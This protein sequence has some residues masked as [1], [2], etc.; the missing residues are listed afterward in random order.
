[1]FILPLKDWKNKRV[2]LIG[3]TH[4]I[5]R[6]LAEH[7]HSLGAII[8]LSGRDRNELTVLKEKLSGSLSF[9]LDVTNQEVVK[10][11]AD[12]LKNCWNQ[13]D[14]FIHCAGEYV[15]MSSANAD[16]DKAR[17]IVNVNF[18]SYFHVFEHVIPWMRTHK[19]GHII[20]IG[21]SAGFIGLPNGFG[22]CASK[23]GVIN[24]AES[25]AVELKDE[26]ISVRLVSPGFVKTRL[27]EKKCLFYAL[28]IIR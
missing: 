21:S 16:F 12:D 28:F 9:P 7:L 4:G 5:G 14:V 26:G 10:K 24:L 3:G 13:I 25:M 20:M 6:A 22:Y 2:W 8:A 18:L 23:A 11:V 15:P 17:Q 19:S 1:M 27:T